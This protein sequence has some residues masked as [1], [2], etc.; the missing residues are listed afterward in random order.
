MNKKILKWVVGGF[1]IIFLG[2][3]GSG[4]W[5]EF[6][7][8]ARSWLVDKIIRSISALSISFKNYIYANASKGFHEEH[9]LTI[10]VVFLGS[11][12][13]VYTAI[14]IVRYTLRLEKPREK[15]RSF[16]GSRKEFVFFNFIV[17]IVLVGTFFTAIQSTYSNKITMKSLNSIEIITPYID[18]KDS[19]LLKSEFLR[20]KTCADYEAFYSKTQNLAQKYKIEL[21]LLKPL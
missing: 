8:P 10:L 7:S 17:L 21:P 4:L 20:V 9:S 11:L 2:A 5:S 14:L 19:L 16:M 18:S 1:G 15:I 6:L 12:A 13:G 3:L